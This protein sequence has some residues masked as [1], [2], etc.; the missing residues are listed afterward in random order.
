M[1]F[2][3]IDYSKAKNSVDGLQIFPVEQSNMAVFA[4]NFYRVSEKLHFDL[5][6]SN[7]NNFF[8]TIKI[9]SL[10]EQELIS[11]Q[12]SGFPIEL[13]DNI[14]RKLFSVTPGDT[15]FSATNMISS[16]EIDLNQVVGQNF[17]ILVNIIDSR[18]EF[19]QTFLLSIN[20]QDII[21][22]TNLTSVSIKDFKTFKQ[23]DSTT[24]LEILDEN[25]YTSNLI[26]S[27]SN[28]RT[29]TGLF[30][31]NAQRFIDERT[32]FPNLIDVDNELQF[33]NF[34]VS[35]QVELATYDS[36]KFG[37][38]FEEVFAIVGTTTVGNLKV[39]NSDTYK[40]YN[41][42][43]ANLNPYAEYETKLIIYFNDITIEIAQQLLTDLR[44]VRTEKN[45][46]E[47][48]DIILR[49]FGNNIPA[50]YQRNVDKFEIISKSDFD[51]LVDKIITLFS[52]EIKSATERVVANQHVASQYTTPYFSL[53]NSYVNNFEQSFDKKIKINSNNNNTFINLTDANFFKTISANQI[54]LGDRKYIKAT[55][56]SFE[57]IKNLLAIPSFS[58]TSIQ[59]EA[60]SQLGLINQANCGDVEQRAD[61]KINFEQPEQALSLITRTER[62]I[63]I[64]YLENL[65]GTVSALD[66]KEIDQK[67]LDLLEPGEKLLARLDNYE[68]FYDSYFYIEGSSV[69]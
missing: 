68:E 2:I 27:F 39:K 34:L 54:S 65:G 13:S 62:D 57:K 26:Y 18:I 33:Q 40:F 37:Y 11:L 52:D 1:S 35:S 55:V 38:D 25:A 64:F 61:A 14:R 48:I 5:N 29:L 30:A 24:I 63:K 53:F 44:E 31:I 36:A 59:G 23:S 15:A 3:N 60:V 10:P 21:D 58:I 28:N 6:I 69:E 22:K 50:E 19:G 49:L 41:F 17:K 32:K 7:L 8:D 51:S 46:Q 16:I 56:K 42:S 20:R 45:R 67:A 66:F 4:S 9:V 12:D 47:A 43:I